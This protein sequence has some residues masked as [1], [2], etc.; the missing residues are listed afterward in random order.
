MIL[1][2]IA[3]VT[4]RS[5]FMR[6]SCYERNIQIQLTRPDVDLHPNNFVFQKVF[7][8]S[9]KDFF[10]KRI[11]NNLAFNIIKLQTAH[12][13]SKNI[14]NRRV[15]RSAI[16]KLF[17]T[18]TT[19]IFYFVIW[20]SPCVLPFSTTALFTSV[21]HLKSVKC[22]SFIAFQMIEYVQHK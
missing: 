5:I 6:K 1:F 12:I 3:F 18:T 8:I 21:V 2:F 14:Q 13:N 22:C 10:F 19:I 17:Q 9:P 20:F 7:L 15:L 11:A 16:L 4:F